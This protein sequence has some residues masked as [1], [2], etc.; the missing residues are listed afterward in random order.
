MATSILDSTGGSPSITIPIDGGAIVVNDILSEDNAHTYKLS[1]SP[2]K[3]LEAAGHFKQWFYFRVHCQVGEKLIFVITDAS[4]ATFP[5]WDGYKVCMSTVGEGEDWTRVKET[6]YED[7]KLMWTIKSASSSIL[8]FS[9]FPPYS[10]ER[11]ER[12][13]QSTLATSA[14]SY[15][16]LGKSEEGRDLHGL[17][18]DKHLDATLSDY[19]VVW[20]QHRQHPGETSASWFCDGVVKRLCEMSR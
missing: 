17:V 15:V 11:Q 12:L 8:S 3:C 2:E 14:C 16:S 19:Y 4:V 7:G 6:F 10:L 5:L 18:F 1:L 13:V 9:Y 20:I